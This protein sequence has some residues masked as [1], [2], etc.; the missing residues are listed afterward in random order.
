MKKFSKLVALALACVMALTML[1]ACGGGNTNAQ[2]MKAINATTQK[3]NHQQVKENADL[4]QIAKELLPAAAAYYTGE[5]KTAIGT[6]T[7][8]MAVRIATMQIDGNS[9]LCSG[10]LFGNQ[11]PQ[12]GEFGQ[13]STF[14]KRDIDYVGIASGKVNGQFVYVVICANKV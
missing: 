4:D 12:N 11:L 6:S 13:Y 1:T 9:V 14:A 5:D 10:C 7:G 2:V 8:K 3:Y